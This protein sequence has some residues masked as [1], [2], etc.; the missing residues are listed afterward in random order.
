MVTREFAAQ[1]QEEGL[2]RELMMMLTPVH[3]ENSGLLLG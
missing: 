3:A 2:E 1:R